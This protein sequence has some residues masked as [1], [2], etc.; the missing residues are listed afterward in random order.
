MDN[1]S[2][3]EYA[4]K[5]PLVVK[6]GFKGLAD[7]GALGIAVALME[8]GNMTFSELKSK[9]GL[10]SST[11]SRHLAA[12]QRGD[13]VRNY[14]EKRDGR[15]YSYYEATNLPGVLLNAVYNALRE[16]A[17]AEAAHSSNPTLAEADGAA[18]QDTMATALMPYL[19]RVTDT[20]QERR[21]D[22]VYAGGTPYRLNPHPPIPARAT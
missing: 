11:L 4:N 12:L 14:Y 17:E 6:A 13:L 8:D 20:G 22:L 5:I 19:A 18:I 3:M 2:L 21:Q 10:N 7:D 15:P 9:F 1:T 16:E